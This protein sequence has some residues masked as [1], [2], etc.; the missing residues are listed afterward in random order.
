M[1]F[2]DYKSIATVLKA[3]GIR[4][5]EEKF[6]EIPEVELSP[7]FLEEFDFSRKYI[8]TGA[9]ESAICENIIYPILREAYKK[10]AD[11]LALWSHKAVRYDEDLSGVPDYLVAKRSELGKV[12]LEKPLLMIVEARKNDFEEGWGRCL[13]EMIAAQKINDAPS[14]VVYGI[15]TDGEVWKF[16]KLLKSEF[17]ENGF[18]LTVSELERVVGA[19]DF[20][21]ANVKKQLSETSDSS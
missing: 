18:L 4:Y 7:G 8:D 21:L 11:D 1:A 20:V 9:S 15:V 6:I 19:L 14:C 10:Y 3:F 13:A 12:V 2:A 16:G 17:A 5:T